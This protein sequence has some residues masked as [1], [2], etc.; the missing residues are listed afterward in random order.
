MEGDVGYV[1]SF[2]DAI[3]FYPRPPGG[4]RHRNIKV[5]LTLTSYFYPRPPGGGRLD[6]VE[7]VNNVT[8]ISIHALRVEG[9]FDSVRH[10]LTLSI[11]IHA[12]RVEGDPALPQAFHQFSISIHALRVEGDVGV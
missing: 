9:D 2:F 7:F 12:L 8:C 3:Y 6:S 1:Q 5:R 4:G 11:S 10:L